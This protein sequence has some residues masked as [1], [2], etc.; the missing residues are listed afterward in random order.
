MT[1]GP[2]TRILVMRHGPAE[3]LGLA[4]SGDF[5]RRLTP[6]GRKRTE[7]ACAVLAQLLPEIGRVY[8][9]PYLRARETADLLAAALSL[10]SPEATPLLA[11]GFDR[12]ALAGMLA[13]ADG[14]ATAVVGH[15]PDLSGF[16]AW[17]SGARV[18][19]DKGTAC[20]IELAQPGTAQ[21]HAL[22]QQESLLN[23]LG[24]D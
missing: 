4:H 14:R 19:M 9:S 22:Y 18:V 1:A 23:A 15:E 13:E 17:M 7:Q 6:A 3:A 12:A 8:T 16:I 2:G 5:D 21:L 10:P 11:P 24:G 20:L